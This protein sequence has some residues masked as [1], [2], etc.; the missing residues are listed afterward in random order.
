MGQTKMENR[1]SGI[2]ESERVDEQ[3]DELTDGKERYI[4]NH[5][6]ENKKS[7]E[8]IDENPPRN[9]QKTNSKKL[10]DEA[11]EEEEEESSAK[12]IISPKSKADRNVD[13]WR[14]K[15][16]KITKQ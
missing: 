13:K 12:N 14:N 6:E 16:S 11:D 2:E 3:D 7:L 8:R 10:E 1:D 4:D 5:E 9:V 15:K